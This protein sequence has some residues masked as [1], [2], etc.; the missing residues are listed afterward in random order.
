MPAHKLS[1]TVHNPSY[2]TGKYSPS[3]WIHISTGVVY[4]SPGVV[5]MPPCV[6]Q[7]SPQHSSEHTKQNQRYT[8]ELYELGIKIDTLDTNEVELLI[9]Y[10]CS[11]LVCR[12]LDAEKVRVWRPRGHQEARDAWWVEE[13]WLSISR[14]FVIFPCVFLVPFH[15]IRDADQ[16]GTSKHLGQPS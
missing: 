8:L 9:D 1:T 16:S 5:K 12:E 14:I 13:R 15:T 3:A 6:L 11:Q 4:A 2:S 10:S 7:M